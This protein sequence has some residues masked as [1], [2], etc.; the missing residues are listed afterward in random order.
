MTQAMLH[1]GHIW[2]SP[3]QKLVSTGNQ[4]LEKISFSGSTGSLDQ[5][6]LKIVG[7]FKPSYWQ[8]QVNGCGLS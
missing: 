8:V 6:K 7:Y 4:L 1:H 2:S 3:I 5:Q